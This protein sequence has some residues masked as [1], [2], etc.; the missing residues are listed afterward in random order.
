MTEKS[1]KNLNPLYQNIL[2]RNFTEEKK[3]I[4]KSDLN[5]L[6]SN[7]VFSDFYHFMNQQSFLL[8][9]SRNHCRIDQV[10][11]FYSNRPKVIFLNEEFFKLSRFERIGTLLHEVHHLI[12][13]VPHTPCPSNRKPFSECDRDYS[14]AYGLE[15]KFY[16]IAGSLDNGHEAL[17]I[18]K[19]NISRILENPL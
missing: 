11:C 5:Y 12:Y 17:Q 16:E 2:G 4:V 15:L 6:A 8:D 14:G 1:F 18:F 3:H 19:K 10:S 13:G 9:F 7:Q